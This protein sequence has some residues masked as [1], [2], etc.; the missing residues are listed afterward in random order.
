MH[1][2]EVAADLDQVLAIADHLVVAAP[3]T[4]AT[5]HL[6]GS[7]ALAK[8][9]PGVHLVN[10]ARGSLIDQDALRQALDS[11]RVA[12]ASLDVVEPEP[13]PAGHWLYQ[14]SAGPA[15]PAHFLERARKPVANVAAVRRRAG[16]ATDPG[17]RC[18]AWSTWPRDTERRP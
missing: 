9:K 17:S 4:A 18:A 10:V 12:M 6:I 3:A 13:L 11:G 7:E 1:G 15:E 8:V 5:R 14:P 16:T 2:V